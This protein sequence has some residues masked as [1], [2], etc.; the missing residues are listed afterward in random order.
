MTEGYTIAFY[1]LAAI[2]GVG[3]I[4]Y[5]RFMPETKPAEDAS[6]AAA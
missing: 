4:L 2:A 6:N 5:A 3:F 1:T